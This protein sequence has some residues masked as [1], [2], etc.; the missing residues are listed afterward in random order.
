MLVA[1]IYDLSPGK[2]T[3]WNCSL[4]EVYAELFRLPASGQRSAN[5][6]IIGVLTEREGLKSPVRDYV[7]TATMINLEPIVSAY[8]IVI[9]E[10][11]SATDTTQFS[12]AR[13]LNK[14]QRALLGCL[15]YR[16]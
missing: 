13:D 2:V 15:G 7:E 3:N 4:D 1:F 9:K 16:K 11:T 6:T 12:L 5:E 14:T 10:A 8:G